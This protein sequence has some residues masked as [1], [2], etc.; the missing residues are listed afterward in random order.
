V[1]CAVVMVVALSRAC[2]AGWWSGIVWCAGNDVCTTTVSLAESCFCTSQFTRPRTTKRA[3]I[4]TPRTSHARPFFYHI[5]LK[6]PSFDKFSMRQ[7]LVPLCRNFLDA[8]LRDQSRGPREAPAGGLIF[9]AA[10]IGPLGLLAPSA[11]SPLH[12]AL[13][14]GVGAVLTR[15]CQQLPRRVDG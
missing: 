15:K 5:P 8:Y 10:L 2:G 4:H 11:N 9:T 12:I 7:S 1:R 3:L 13:S 14:L 6:S